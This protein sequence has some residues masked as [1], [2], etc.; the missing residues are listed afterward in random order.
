MVRGSR[1]RGAVPL[2][3]RVR[4]VC[5]VGPNY[6]APAP[7][8]LSVPDTYYGRPAQSAPAELAR[9]WERFDDP[10]LTRLIAEATR[11]KLDL[12]AAAARLTQA[13]ESLVQARAGLVPTVGASAGA[14]RT[15]GAGNDHN[16]FSVGADAAWEVDL[17]GRIRRGVEAAGADAEGAWF[18]REALR[19]AIAAEV[20]TNYVQARV[21]PE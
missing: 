1:I 14:G 17:F 2:C 3:V 8:A 11:D 9:W 4:S 19:V 21:A 20:A 16:S 7:A 5:T 15:M 18:D 10:M 13:R 6:R 12:A